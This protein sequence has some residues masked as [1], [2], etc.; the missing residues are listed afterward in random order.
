[1]GTKLNNNYLPI[2]LAGRVPVKVST[3]NGVIK[4]GDYLTSSTIPGVAMK[5]INAG[6]VIGKALESFNGLGSSQLVSS[7][8]LRQTNDETSSATDGPQTKIGKILMFV[9]LSWYGGESSEIVINPDGTVN[10]KVIITTSGGDFLGN[11][12]SGLRQLGVDIADGVIKAA[13]LVVNEVKTKVLRI[14]V[15]QGKDAT[16]GSATIPAQQIEFRVNNTLVEANS[17]IFVSFTT[18]TGGRTWY[19]SEK[20]AGV[21]FTIH[22]S[23]VTPEPLDFDYWIILVQDQDRGATQIESPSAN[24]QN[25]A[26]NYCG[27]GILYAGEEC[28]DGNLVDGDGC[29]ATCEIEVPPTPTPEPTLEPTPTPEPEPVP[30]PEPEPIVEPVPEAT[31]S[32]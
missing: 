12:T 8:V 13:Q 5:A 29:S 7:D 2:S 3:E 26:E 25:N 11:L 28:D 18:D 17:K 21:G 16:V 6:P 27:D 4:E 19:I 32:E 1:L 23:D 31:V 20:V 24:T 10:D 15:E 22:L 14:S 9:N 30:E